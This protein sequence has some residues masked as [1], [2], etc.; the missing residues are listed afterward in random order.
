MKNIFVALLCAGAF[1]LMAADAAAPDK[2]VAAKPK[3]T[4]AEKTTCESRPQ[5]RPL[6]QWIPF[7]M[8]FFP[9]VPD[10][11][12]NS[13]VIGIKSGWPMVDGYGRV[14]GLEASWLYSGTDYIRGIQASFIYSQ[15]RKMDGLQADFVGSLNTDT[16]NGIQ[17]ALG[18]CYNQNGFYGLQSA[19]A[20]C[21]SGDFTG[22]QASAVNI[23]GNVRGFQAAAVTNVT[24]DVTGFQASVVCNKVGKLTGFQTALINDATASEGIQFGLINI[25]KSKGLQFGLINYIEDAPLKWFPIVNFA[26]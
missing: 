2:Q 6:D 9:G 26:L 8:G 20:Y 23:S 19:L 22:L 18:F 11:T 5:L 25:S 16:F 7:Q 10:G 21:Q 15:N 17:G 14:Y 12:V 13:N 3:C 4:A 24:G 1:S